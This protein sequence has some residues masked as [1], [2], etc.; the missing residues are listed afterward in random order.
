MSDEQ[1]PADK[2]PTSLQES[3][4]TMLAFGGDKGQ[5]VAGMVSPA[6]FEAPYNDIA[7][8][9]IEYRQK[10]GQAPG[11]EHVDDLFDHVLQDPNN[12]QAPLFQRILLALCKQSDG[13]NEQYVLDRVGEFARR[14]TYKSVIYRAGMRIQQGGDEVADDVESILNEAFKFRA[15]NSHAGVFLDRPEALAFMEPNAFD[16]LKLGIDYFDHRDICPTRGEL[17]L[18]I[19]PRGRGKSWLATHCTTMALLQRWRVADITLEMSETRKTQRIYQNLLG[20]AKRDEKY[21]QTVFTLDSLGRLEGFDIELRKP[22]VAMDRP[23]ALSRIKKFQTDWSYHLSRLNVRGFPSGSLTVSK[24][25]AHLDFLEQVHGFIPDMVVVDYPQ[26]MYLD[27]NA[28]REALG[29]TFVDLRGLAQQ[30]NIAVVALHQSNREGE[31]ATNLRSQHASEDISIIGTADIALTYNA[32]EAER[33]RGVAR[34]YAAKVRNDQ[35]DIS[36]HITQ[37]YNTGQFVIQSVPGVRNYWG[38]FETFK[39]LAMPGGGT[40]DTP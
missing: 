40:V 37:N 9:A 10:Y 23:D 29:R 30:R 33:V 31:T 13:L 1:F 6:L 7:R 36:V 4:L 14:Q 2:L 35:G 38:L 34:L 18:F 39:G 8:R 24:L 15:E 19:A 21:P 25:R 5:I 26:I 12:K 16:T 3:I 28:P 32:T 20:M 22:T 27:P 17:F 11:V